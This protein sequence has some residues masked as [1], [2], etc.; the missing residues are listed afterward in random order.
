MSVYPFQQWI[1]SIYKYICTC[2]CIH[3]RLKDNPYRHP[4]KQRV[5]QSTSQTDICLAQ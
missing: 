3:N 1:T 2:L 5:G 4:Y